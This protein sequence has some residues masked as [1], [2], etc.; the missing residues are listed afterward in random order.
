MINELH[1]HISCKSFDSELDLPE[2][3]RKLLSIAADARKD[4]YAPY[5]KFHVGAAMLMAD[6][7]I[8]K[9]SNQ[10]NASYPLGFCA[11]RTALSAAASLAS[12]V[13]IEAI[14]IKVASEEMEID[15]PTAPCGICRQVLLEAEMK[16]KHD[17][18]IL[19]QGNTGKVYVFSSAKDLLPLHFD[20]TYL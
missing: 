18:R 20:S 3:D 9:G 4:S 19:L 10:E 16:H 6:K 12:G 11:E 5:S 14:A 17:I 1:F 8:V 2:A 7:T 13:A 15:K